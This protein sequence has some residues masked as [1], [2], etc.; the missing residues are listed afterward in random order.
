[1]TT[2]VEAPWESRRIEE[3]LARKSQV[4]LRLATVNVG[5]MLEE[6]QKL[7]KPSEEEMW[8]CG[9]FTRGAI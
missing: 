1:M 7:Q 8:I 5:T 6:V 4:K 9:G 3:N 2:P